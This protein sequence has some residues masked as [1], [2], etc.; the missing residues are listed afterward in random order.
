MSAGAATPA[1]DKKRALLVALAPPKRRPAAAADAA[2]LLPLAR[3]S[4]KTPRKPFACIPL[5]LSLGE[6][7]RCSCFLAGQFTPAFRVPL[8]FDFLLLVD[9]WISFGKGKPCSDDPL[10]VC[11]LCLSVSA[12][13]ETFR[14]ID[15]IFMRDVLNEENVVFR[16]S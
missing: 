12:A 10:C 1:R 13:P 7:D 9:A 6:G 15:I 16:L 5:F 3:N 8:P 14:G 4:P 11:C 2:I